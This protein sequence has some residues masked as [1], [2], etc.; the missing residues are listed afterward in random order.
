IKNI[1]IR[2][3]GNEEESNPDLFT[4]RL[5]EGSYILLCSDGLT[6]CVP[7]AD[8]AAAVSAETQKELDDCAG[9]L[10][11]LANEGGGIDNITIILGK[12]V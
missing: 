1:I 2:S 10:I 11:S 3:V 9:Q 8:I 5:S 7:K 4:L 12:I 6:N